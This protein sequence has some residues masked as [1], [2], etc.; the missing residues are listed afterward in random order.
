MNPEEIMKE[1][2]GK[3]VEKYIQGHWGESYDLDTVCRHMEIHDAN[4]REA[5][6]QKLL[7]EH[8]AGRLEK[9]NKHYRSIDTTIE[10]MNWR[11]SIG[12]VNLPLNYPT[13]TDGSQFGFDGHLFIPEK[14]LIVL[15]G[16][17]NTGKSVFMRNLLFKNMDIHHCVYFSSET[18]EDDFAEYL[19]RMTWGNPVNDD[20]SDK[21]DAIFRDKDFKYV[22]QPN[23]IN[24]VDWFNIYD[25]FYRIGEVLDSMKN[26]LN[27][28]I[29]A[30]A[31]Q[32]D[33][34][35]G[36]GVG[37]MWAEHKASLYMT[38][39]FGRLTVEKAKKWDGIN[40]NHKTWGFEIVD[41]G[42]HF[43][44][45]RPLIKCHDCWGTG[46]KKGVECTNCNGSG[47]ADVIIQTPKTD[48][49]N[50]TF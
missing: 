5:I 7:Y 10:K 33:P 9:N 19:S 47:W 27:K 3:A 2:A 38:M 20:G 4:K 34:Q 26:V 8:R 6:N 31:I 24:L 37:G 23:A 12:A 21:F 50:D 36:L 13:G 49:I 25:E 32:K 29:L 11:D 45:I 35:K 46:K 15:A 43:N 42:T 22:I 48:Y 41:Q 40:P 16:V 30:V 28:G 39:D 1:K 17:T 44:N 18:S 14:G